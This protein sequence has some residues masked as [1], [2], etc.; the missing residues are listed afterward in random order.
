MLYSRR[1]RGGFEEGKWN[2]DGTFEGGERREKS[3]LLGREVWQ[4]LKGL[5]VGFENEP[6]AIM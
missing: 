5:S 1:E 2:L 4:S 3:M 6:S